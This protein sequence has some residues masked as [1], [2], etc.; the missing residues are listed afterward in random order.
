M[1]QISKENK[2]ALKPHF[3]S[4]KTIEIA[5][6]QIR[7]GAVGIT[8]ATLKETEALVHNGIE[9]ITL[10]YPLI[11]HTKIDTFKGL[12]QRDCLQTIVLDENHGAYL[13]GF[14]SEKKPLNAWLKI[15]TGLNR[16]GIQPEA[17]PKTLKK[18]AD[19]K[20]IHVVGLLTHAGHSYGGHLDLKTIGFDEGKQLVAYKEKRLRVSC[21]STPTAKWVAKVPGVDEI[22]P[23]NYVF[24]DGT[25]VA[26]GVCQKK[27]CA[28]FVK[29]TIIGKY[30]HHLVIDSGS[31][32]LGLDKGVHGNSN[33]EGFGTIMGADSLVITRLSE[34]HGIIEGPAIKHFEIGD[35][36][37]LL[38]NHACPVVNLQDTLYVFSNNQLIDNYTVVGRGH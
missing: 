26:L 35:R 6:E 19:L 7:R 2:V 31:K 4:H 12:A 29:T 38:P 34:E 22:R 32:M 37:T 13:N 18:L 24:Y 20:N 11:G 21:G 1:A 8:T 36:L 14:F 5:Q 3:K 15:D 27:D 10:A 28:L 16:L 9:N 23:G 17:I 30:E 33:L 25:M